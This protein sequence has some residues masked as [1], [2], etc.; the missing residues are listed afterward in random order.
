MVQVSNSFTEF[1]LSRDQTEE[2]KGWMQVMFVWYHYF[3]A[4]EWYNWIRVYIACYVWMTGFG[5]TRFMSTVFVLFLFFR[6]TK[7]PC[8][9]NRELNVI[10]MCFLKLYRQYCISRCVVAI[11]VDYAL[12]NNFGSC[13]FVQETSHSSG[14]EETILCGAF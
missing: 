11:F 2:W 3:A 4:K 7:L 6:V 13:F 9:K 14:S 12:F 1:C 8:C 10:Q 5:E